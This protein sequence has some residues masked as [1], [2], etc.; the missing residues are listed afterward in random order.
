MQQ[1]ASLRA[2]ALDFSIAST[3]TSYPDASVEETIREFAERL[4]DH[5]Q[6]KPFVSALA[7]PEGFDDL[8]ADY[9]A[10][11]DRGDGRIPLY[12]TEYGRMRGIAKGNA[13]ADIAGFY[14]AFGLA[15]DPDRHEL[16][17]HAAVELEFYAV[18]LA[19]QDYLALA[20]DAEGCAIVEDAR[21]KF[22]KEHLGPLAR[23]LAASPVAREH[24][25]YG[26]VLAWCGEIVARECDALDVSP[27][28][29]DFFAEDSDASD[30]ECGAV[31]LPVVP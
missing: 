8:R 22:L 21:K 12:E 2:R 27:V 16:L 15:P 13:L 14:R 20:N 17:D 23:A 7:E 3:L 1:P 4:A 6:A 25:A 30:L 18:L 19:K 24:A 31:R 9:V 26:D 10:L 29:L 28:P 11:F 5:A